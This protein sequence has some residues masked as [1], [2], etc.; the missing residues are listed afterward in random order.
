MDSAQTWPGIVLIVYLFR[1]LLPEVCF[2]SEPLASAL[3]IHSVADVLMQSVSQ[4]LF[5]AM[6]PPPAS[7][8]TL[9]ENSDLKLQLKVS[10]RRGPRTRVLSGAAA[11]DLLWRCCCR[12][13]ML[14]LADLHLRP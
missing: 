10:L 5:P 7:D 11:L 9:K 4:K 12:C 3:H 14:L 2:S 8:A 13:R 6:T 1:Q